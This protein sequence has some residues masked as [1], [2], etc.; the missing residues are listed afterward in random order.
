MTHDEY[1]ESITAKRHDAAAVERQAE[2][3]RR[4]ED[5]C[6]QIDGRYKEVRNCI[7]M[8]AIGYALSI[9]SAV[10]CVLSLAAGNAWT[11]FTCAIMAAAGLGY[12]NIMAHRLDE[13]ER[14][15]K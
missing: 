8:A 3:E 2:R 9:V 13:L 5:I 10:I 4:D 14:G 15:N 11:L 7:I 1:L 6:R 12:A